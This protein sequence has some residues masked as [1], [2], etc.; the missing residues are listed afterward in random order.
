MIL[1]EPKHSEAQYF[2]GLILEKKGDAN[3]A[4]LCFEQAIKHNTSKKFVSK[5]LYEIARIKIEG[6]NFYEA[7]HAINRA[8]L[9][10]LDQSYFK[11]LKLFTEGVC[12]FSPIGLL[13]IYRLSSS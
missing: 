10:G 8:E 3:E 1:E 9:L 6:R 2:K 12:P 7:C 5:S 13:T 4:I 11:K